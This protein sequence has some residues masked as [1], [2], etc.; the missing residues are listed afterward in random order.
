MVLYQ[1][2]LERPPCIGALAFPSSALA[3]IMDLDPLDPVYVNER[4]SKPP[5]VTIEGVVNIRDLG[6]Y[7]TDQPGYITKPGLLY[8]SGEISAITDEGE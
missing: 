5:F 8:R 7:P 3:F 1:V 2:G 6:S 4:L